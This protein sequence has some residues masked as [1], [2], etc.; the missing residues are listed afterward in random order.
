MTNYFTW[1]RK[2][3]WVCNNIGRKATIFFNTAVSL[4]FKAELQNIFLSCINH[5]GD[6]NEKKF[7][8][9]GWNIPGWNFLGG[10]FPGGIHQGGVWWVG[11]SGWEFSWYHLNETNFFYSYFINSFLLLLHDQMNIYMYG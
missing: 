7:K 8:N 5:N 10:N 4:T 3:F 11:F 1:S 9:P 2:L 6:N